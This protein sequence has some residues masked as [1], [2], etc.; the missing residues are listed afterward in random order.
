M[1]A[2]YIKQGKSE[3]CDSCDRPSNLTQIGF[4]SS[5]F[6]PLWPWNFFMDDLL[7]I[8]PNSSMNS[9]WSCSLETLNS[10]KNWWFFVPCDLENW[11]MTLENNRAPLLYYVKLCE[12]FQS[13]QWI[14]TRVTIWK[15]SIQVK[16][17]HFLSCVTSKFDGWPWITRATLTPK[18][19]GLPRSIYV[20]HV[21]TVKQ[22]VPW[23]SLGIWAH[24]EDRDRETVW[25]MKQ[26]RYS[27]LS[28]G[29]VVPVG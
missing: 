23:N 4:E 12:S 21:E 19:P 16:I 7:C 6:K 5:I 18:Y 14:Q 13:H 9:N 1:K 17:G 2:S 27:W 28:G 29:Y 26:S 20:Q 15:H 25:P 10:G 11:W 3:G 22:S 24:A 8:I